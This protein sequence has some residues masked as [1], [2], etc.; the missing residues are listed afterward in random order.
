MTM[1]TLIL[2]SQWQPL[3]NGSNKLQLQILSGEVLYTESA[4]LPGTDAACFVLHAG[5]GLL[6]IGPEASYVRA[7]FGT[8]ILTVLDRAGA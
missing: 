2:D 6:D 1:K 4:S 8:A 7:S 3:T 5:M